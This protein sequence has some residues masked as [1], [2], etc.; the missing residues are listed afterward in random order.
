MKLSLGKKQDFCKLVLYGILA[1]LFVNMLLNL[2]N[3]R[4]CFD[5]GLLKNDGV[6]TPPPSGTPSPS[7]ETPKTPER[8][9]P[10]V[11]VAK[12]SAEKKEV[13]EKKE[14]E[15]KKVK[16][17]NKKEVKLNQ[18]QGARVTSK[19]TLDAEVNGLGKNQPEPS[20]TNGVQNQSL[21]AYYESDK[22]AS[23]YAPF[24]SVSSAQPKNV[25]EQPKTQQRD[26]GNGKVNQAI[27]AQS[28]GKNPNTNKAQLGGAV[29]KGDKNPTSPEPSPV[30]ERNTNMVSN[31]K[32]PAVDYAPVSA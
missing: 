24:V 31:K 20:L 17:V 25:P 1:Y 23:D 29:K 32:D 27:F 9:P 16:P 6:V 14:P 18:E 15:L 21:S 19:T 22:F 7:P 11:S 2:K 10:V 8:A 12:M 13:A 3:G 5:L 30:A 26:L 4:S 28:G